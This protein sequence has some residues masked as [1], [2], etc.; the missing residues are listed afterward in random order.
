MNA[1]HDMAELKKR[2][3]GDKR[4][5]GR[6]DHHF[7]INIFDAGNEPGFSSPYR[8]DFVTAQR[9]RLSRE[10]VISKLYNPGESGLPDNSDAG[11][12]ESLLM[13]S[14]SAHILVARC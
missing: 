4:V 7:D 14:R 5:F 6:L 10:V 9:W 13:V 11:A 1:T 8:Y 3:G 2:I 12:K